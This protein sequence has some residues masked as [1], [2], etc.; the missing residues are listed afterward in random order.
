METH[1]GQDWWHKHGDSVSLVFD[2]GPKSPALRQLRDYL[3]WKGL[4]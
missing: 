4:P 1:R 2:L 3:R